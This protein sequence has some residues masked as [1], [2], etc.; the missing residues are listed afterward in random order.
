[1]PASVASLFE[2]VAWITERDKLYGV[3][4]FNTVNYS[5][6]RGNDPPNSGLI[7]VHD[8]ESHS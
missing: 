1:M 6:F 7:R 4:P 2:S 8:D 5:R 3:E